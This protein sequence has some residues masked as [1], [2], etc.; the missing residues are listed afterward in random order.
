MGRQNLVVVHDGEDEQTLYPII[1]VRWGT[2]NE[3]IQQVSEQV[4]WSEMLRSEVIAL[5]A[6]RL[7]RQM[8]ID[9][10]EEMELK[11]S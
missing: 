8:I 9:E 4:E 1:E 3:W 2:H 6:A 7:R 5:N 10:I 11:L